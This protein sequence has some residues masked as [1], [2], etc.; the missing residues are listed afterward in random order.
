M[1]VTRLTGSIEQR[2]PPGSS[3]NVSFRYTVSHFLRG[4]SSNIYILDSHTKTFACHYKLYTH[5]N[6]F[7]NITVSIAHRPIWAY[8]WIEWNACIGTPYRVLWLAE[9]SLLSSFNK[10]MGHLMVSGFRRPWIQ[11]H[12]YAQGYLQIKRCVSFSCKYPCEST[13]LPFDTSPPTKAKTG[14]KLR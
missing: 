11:S 12:R 6:T 7:C 3:Y 5:T 2:R 1:N 9:L 14:F 4:K 10:Q 13:L 8:T